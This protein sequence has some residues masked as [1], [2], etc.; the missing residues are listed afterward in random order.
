MRRAGDRCT[1]RQ[2]QIASLPGWMKA[3]IF[4][5]TDE[6]EQWN[7]IHTHPAIAPRAATRTDD[8]TT[9]AQ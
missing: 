1:S 9:A 4:V 5:D 6:P 7:A 3:V 8:G 2:G